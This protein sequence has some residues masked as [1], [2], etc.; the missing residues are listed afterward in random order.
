[1]K[2][3]TMNSHEL[4]NSCRFVY[5]RAG[6]NGG[7]NVNKV[8]TKVILFIDIKNLSLNNAEKERLLS[9]YA[10]RITEKGELEI[11]SQETR[12]Q[13]QNKNKCLEKL[14]K[15]LEDAKSIPKA[16]KKIYRPRPSEKEIESTKRKI[17]IKALRKIKATERE[18]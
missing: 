1:M 10:N 18:Q 13:L 16:R 6:G 2:I 9:L 3:E 15:I 5:A 17:Q 14:E 12:S 11:V 7:Q 4:E 8:E